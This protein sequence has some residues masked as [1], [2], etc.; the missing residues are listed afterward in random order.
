MNCPNCN[1]DNNRVTGVPRSVNKRSIDFRRYRKC[2][3]CGK[4]FKTVEYWVPDEIVLMKKGRRN[5][6]KQNNRNNEN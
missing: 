2:L 6:G 3:T 1:T 4:Y 5:N